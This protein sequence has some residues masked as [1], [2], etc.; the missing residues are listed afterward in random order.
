MIFKNR[1]FAWKLSFY[2]LSAT[3][4]LGLLLISLNYNISRYLLF[5][6]VSESAANKAGKN[7]YKIEP[8]C[9]QC[10]KSP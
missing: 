2:I 7:V 3:V 1:P 6:S 4:L 10:R 5:E 8:F 9:R